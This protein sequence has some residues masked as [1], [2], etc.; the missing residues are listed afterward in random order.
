VVPRQ[1]WPLLL[2]ALLLVP[3]ATGQEGG[4]TVFVTD[5]EGTVTRGTALQV[6]DAIEE[7][8]EA[9]RPLVIR[10]DTPGGLVD[11]TLDIGTAVAR[12]DVPVLT[13]VRGGGWA[14]SA[15]TFIFLMGHPNGM[16]NGTQIGSAQPIVQ[17]QSGGTQNA[18][19]KVTNALLER[20][21]SI[22]DR[23]GRNPDVAERFI[24]ENLNLNASEAQRRGM[25]D[26]TAN[27][28][29]A[30]LD[31]VHGEEANVGEGTRTLATANAQL[32]HVEEGALV[33]LVEV[34]GNPQVAFVLFLIGLYGVI[35]GLAAPGTLVPETIG[36]LALVLGLVGLGLFDAGTSG[37]LL[38]LLASAF[39]VA[40]IFT[41]THGVLATAGAVALVL[42][43]IF[44]LDEPLLSRDFLHRFQIVAVIS[45]VFSGGVA[46]GAVA[47]AVR[48]REQPPRDTVEGREAETLSSLD[49]EGQVF[50]RGE[51]WKARTADRQTIAEGRTVVIEGRDGLT[52]VVR[53]ADAPEVDP[54]DDPPAT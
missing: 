49:P 30:F 26:H 10:L 54:P 31:A 32:E 8:E 46:L 52:L 24:T 3:A 11:A 18:S 9:D 38:I 33:Q 45:A 21:R 35:F 7:A 29:H 15:G 51:R 13:Y 27:D 43:A 50:F 4:S 2:I 36:A 16:A 34:V 19:E 23:N 41:P 1:L 14:Q 22:A 5:V 40:E 17:S 6:E 25:S 53:P 42:G 39:F 28:V 12:S 37:L 48:T 47:L 20:I 44:L